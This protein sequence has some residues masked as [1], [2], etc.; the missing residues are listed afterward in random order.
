[1]K[2][3]Q[4]IHQSSIQKAKAQSKIDEENSKSEK[5]KE[6]KK[7]VTPAP[8]IKTVRIYRWNPEKPETKP[9]IQQHKV[10][11]SKCGTMVLDVLRRIKHEHDPTLAF[12]FSCREGICG[13][14]AMNINGVNTLACIT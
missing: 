7:A 10:D 12:R 3:K 8:K 11:L 2:G 1:M 6:K 4:W 13:S 14:C 9:Y 5:C